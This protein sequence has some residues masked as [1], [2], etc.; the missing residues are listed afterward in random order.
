[1]FVEVNTEAFNALTEK[2][3]DRHDILI[4][5]MVNK[6]IN[7]SE[8]DVVILAQLSMARAINRLQ[9]LEIPVLT[10]PEISSKAIMDKVMKRY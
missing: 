10:S 9:N 2:D 3:Y 6:L 5:E 4:S 1:V 8:I 7:E